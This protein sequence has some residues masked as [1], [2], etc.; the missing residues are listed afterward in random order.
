MEGPFDPN[1]F[2]SCC[3]HR[4]ISPAVVDI[5]AGSVRSLDGARAESSAVGTAIM[6]G[7]VSAAM[8]GSRATVT[9]PVIGA[10]VIAGA[11]V[12]IVP[13]AGVPGAVG[14]TVSAG[15]RR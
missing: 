11:P 8:I 6:V 7:S 15:V 3:G 4:R 13:G 9:G 10:P 12:A 2:T 1:H 14:V 5:D